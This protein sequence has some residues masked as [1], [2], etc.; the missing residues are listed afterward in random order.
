MMSCLLA[1]ILQYLKKRSQNA[2]YDAL[3]KLEEGSFLSVQFIQ[4]N[5]FTCKELYVE[6]ELDSLA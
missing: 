6:Y 5:I 1:W 3:T 4:F 2:L